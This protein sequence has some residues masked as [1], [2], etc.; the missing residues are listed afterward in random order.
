MLLGFIRVYFSYGDGSVEAWCLNTLIRK[1]D[2]GTASAC[3]LQP[4]NIITPS[5]VKSENPELRS[6]R[7]LG[8][9][10]L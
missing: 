7:I 3:H 6:S 9:E 5:Q 2:H 8:I 10:Y 4:F 1:R